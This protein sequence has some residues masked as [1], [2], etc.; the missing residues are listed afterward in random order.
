[1]RR[2]IYRVQVKL[3]KN[4]SIPEKCRCKLDQPLGVDGGDLSHVL[5][6]GLHH[7]V[8][9]NPLGLAVEQR[10]RR[11]NCNHLIGVEF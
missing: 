7:L 8:E 2:F 5:L 4:N 3:Q 1:M 9:H 6:G 10:A 11:V